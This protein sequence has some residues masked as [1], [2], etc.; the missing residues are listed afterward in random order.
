M[1]ETIDL[2]AKNIISTNGFNEH[3]K[4]N[5]IHRITASLATSADFPPLLGP[6]CNFSMSLAETWSN[7]AKSPVLSEF[8]TDVDNY[9][10]FTSYWSHLGQDGGMAKRKRTKFEQNLL[11]RIEIRKIRRQE[12]DEI[13]E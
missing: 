10:L 3:A 5:L 8:S 12:R 6:F 2:M 9:P 11:K 1:K 13:L 4:L 7:C